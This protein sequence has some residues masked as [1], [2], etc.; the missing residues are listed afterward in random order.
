MPSR[1]S[2]KLRE[3]S[4]TVR[5][6]RRIR[7]AHYGTPHAEPRGVRILP[8]VALLASCQSKPAPDPDTPGRSQLAGLAAAVD[9]AHRRMHERFGAARQIEYSIARGDLPNATTNAHLI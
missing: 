4:Q 3:V 6:S 5:I 9:D 7:L 1:S 2:R 8:F